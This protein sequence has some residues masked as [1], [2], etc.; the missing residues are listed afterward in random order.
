MSKRCAKDVIEP[1]RRKD[2][3]FSGRL[4]CGSIGDTVESASGRLGFSSEWFGVA[5][6]SFDGPLTIGCGK[7]VDRAAQ[8]ER[9]NIV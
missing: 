3:I 7:E 5:F 1:A 8:T 9:L 4:H 2:N 6:Q